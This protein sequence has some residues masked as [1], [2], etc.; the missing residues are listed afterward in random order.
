VV[1]RYVDFVD[2]LRQAAAVR[3]SVGLQWY[4]NAAARQV[5][6]QANAGRALE[7]ACDEALQSRRAAEL[8][9]GGDGFVIA[10]LFDPCDRVDGVLA[11][12]GELADLPMLL[13]RLHSSFWHFS[14]T[15]HLLPQVV[16]TARPNGTIDYVSSRWGQVIGKELNPRDVHAEVLPAIVDDDV[17]AFA[18]QWKRGTAGVS[19]FSMEMRLR[20]LEGV[21]WYELR[22]NPWTLDGRIVKWIVSLTDVDAAVQSRDALARSRERFEYL[23]R[24]MLPVTLPFVPGVRLDFAYEPAED[25]PL[26]GGDWYDAFPLPDGRVALAVGDVAG[27]GLESA[28]TM[29]HAR[30]SMRVAAYKNPDPTEVLGHANAAVRAEGATM[31]TAF[32]GVLDPL[33]LTLEY[34]N[35]G[36]PPPLV[37]DPFGTATDLSGAGTALGVF[38]VVSVSSHSTILPAESALV[39]FTDGLVK[40]GR[41][42]EAGERRLREVLADWA[43]QGFSASAASVQDA[44]IGG[45]P[46]SDDVALFI[47]RFP[48]VEELA[49]TIP[50]TGLAAQRARSA[51]RRF[52]EAAPLEESRAR[53]YVLAIGEALSNAVEHA[54][55]EPGGTVRLRLTR[56]AMGVTAVVEDEGRW[57]GPPSENRGRGLMLMRKLTDAFDL[58]ATDRGTTVRM[59]LRTLYG[60]G[61]KPAR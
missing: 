1:A 10:P 23:Q 5:I 46:P 28:V 34:A 41:E 35:A 40:I 7:A 4:A 53:G 59:R 19:P 15:V 11:V 2:R 61:A 3:L 22:A 8:A 12:L 55:T 13:S 18:R 58:E 17:P 60:V 43:R 14:Q 9:I 42:L 56:D 52:L 32:F 29:A 6:D 25:G 54:Y 31:V 44:V 16:L 45:R 24:A 21:R 33:N 27:H 57:L 26:A 49:L 47:V 38:D 37:V 39:L 30:Q 20:T 36:H 51:V 48:H 50:A